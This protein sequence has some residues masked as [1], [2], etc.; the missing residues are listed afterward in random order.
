MG[1]ARLTSEPG[2]ELA[3]DPGAPLLRPASPG[4]NEVGFHRKKKKIKLLLRPW[5]PVT[6]PFPSLQ[7]GTYGEPKS[8][9]AILGDMCGVTG[10]A[11][12]PMAHGQAP[13]LCSLDSGGWRGMCLCWGE[14]FN[15]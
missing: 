5:V 9:E 11:R 8:W 3:R 14:T 2:G 13:T 7:K 12:D 1:L 6:R 10:R 15:Y 4:L